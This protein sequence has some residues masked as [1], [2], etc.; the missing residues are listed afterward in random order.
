[1][2]WTV[3]T[4]LLH[5]CRKTPEGE[6]WLQRLPEAVGDVEYEWSLTLG[7]PFDGEEVSCAWV[8]PVTR[9][10]GTPA[11]LKLSLPHFETERESDGLRFWDGEPTVRLLAA[12]AGLGAM[13]LERCE[14]GTVL[15]ERPEAEQDLVIA[16]LLRRLWRPPSAPHS[17]RSLAAML[18]HWSAETF[19]QAD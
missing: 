8:A 19:A 17:F 5:T 6:A 2:E 9:A 12:D 14:P 15:R 11:V 1:M 3:P 10:D 18:E 4:Q 13:L 7:T 16:G